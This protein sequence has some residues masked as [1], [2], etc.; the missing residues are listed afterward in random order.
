MR[1]TTP[2]VRTSGTTARHEF[3][4]A[5]RAAKLSSCADA[6]T[7]ARSAPA[8]AASSPESARNSRLSATSTCLSALAALAESGRSAWG[9]TK[10]VAP[11]RLRAT[12]VPTSRPRPAAAATTHRP[13][14]RRGCASRSASFVTNSGWRSSAPIASEVAR[15]APA[16]RTRRAPSRA[17]PLELSRTP[18]PPPLPPPLLSKAL[19]KASSS[20][21][22]GAA[23]AAIAAS[24][25][26]SRHRCGS[27]EAHSAVASSASSAALTS[28]SSGMP[29]V[30]P[31]DASRPPS[32]I[33]RS[34]RK[35]GGS[36]RDASIASA[37]TRNDSRH[38][39]GSAANTGCRQR[40]R[41][42]AVLAWAA[43]RS[44]TSGRPRATASGP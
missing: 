35:G 20:R 9:S 1:R 30:A 21:G 13:S 5:P 28:D 16:A 8:C 41:P 14:R 34:C 6:A 31:P 11:D 10:A 29:S 7:E 15:A 27:A 32:R 36:V 43:S 44:R 40:F 24:R 38:S 4:S 12:S 3:A 26:R 17:K 42:G 23:W 19:R 22:G 18:L 37:T 39:A 2:A 25:G 33:A